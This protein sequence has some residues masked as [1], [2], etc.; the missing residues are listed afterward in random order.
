MHYEL[1]HLF[2]SQSQF[3]LIVHM[4]TNLKTHSRFFLLKSVQTS[5]GD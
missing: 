4:A 1:H 3:D 2:Y 5:Q